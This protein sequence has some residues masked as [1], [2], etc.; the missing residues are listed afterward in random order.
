MNVPA[1]VWSKVTG[2]SPEEAAGVVKELSV[3]V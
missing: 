1:I 2:L 3:Q